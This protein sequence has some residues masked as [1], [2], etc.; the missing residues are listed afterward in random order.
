MQNPNRI[1]V[2][3]AEKALKSVYD[4]VNDEA[5]ADMLSDL[6]HLVRCKAS[7][8]R[9]ARPPRLPQLRQRN[10]RWGM[11]YEVQHNTAAGWV[12]T[13]PGPTQET[14]ARWCPKLSR[15]RRKPKPLLTNSSMTS[16]T[17]STPAIRQPDEG[18]DR[19]EFRIHPTQTNHQ[20]QT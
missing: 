4:A 12:N 11:T 2:I 13:W 5:I 14:T 10:G 16:V 8:L 9:Q 19:S 1:H 6:R 7:G 15:H 3:T 20:P 17:R 18:Y